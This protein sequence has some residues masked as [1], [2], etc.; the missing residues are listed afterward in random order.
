DGHIVLDRSLAQAGIYPAI[1]IE[2]SISRVMSNIV[3]KDHLKK[4]LNFKQSWS[5]YEKNRDLINVGAYR[6]GA[7][8]AI[9]QAITRFP[10][11]QKFMQQGA[12]EQSDMAASKKQLFSLITD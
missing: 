7:D 5:L 9:D 8:P 4:V 10:L 12:T 1:S 3:E 6:R 2:Q 11:L